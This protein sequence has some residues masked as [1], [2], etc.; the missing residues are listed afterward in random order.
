[1]FDRAVDVE[2]PALV[3]NLRAK[4]EVEDRPIPGEMLPRRQALLFGPRDLAGDETALL[5]PALLGANELARGR[6]V[7]LGHV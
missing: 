6:P 1:M 7:F 2:P 4:A 3:W 5:C